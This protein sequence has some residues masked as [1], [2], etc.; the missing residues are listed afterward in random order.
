MES[1]DLGPVP[2]GA[3]D[4]LAGSECQFSNCHET[5]WRSPSTALILGLGCQASSV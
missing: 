3:Q 2:F 5:G 1:L 4:S